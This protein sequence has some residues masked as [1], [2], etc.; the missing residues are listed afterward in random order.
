[1]SALYSSIIILILSFFQIKCL[2]YYKAEIIKSNE[3]VKRDIPTTE[4][5]F[6]IAYDY[7]NKYLKFKIFEIINTKQ[8]VTYKK[9]V[10]IKKTVKKEI[11]D[12]NYGSPDKPIAC[13]NFSIV[14]FLDDSMT[15][16]FKCS[17]GYWDQV[18][19]WPILSLG[20]PYLWTIP[21]VIF[22]S[23]TLPFRTL[24]DARTD[25]EEKSEMTDSKKKIPSEKM[26]LF[27]EDN[28]GER[29]KFQ[30]QNGIVSIP[31]A[32]IKNYES[33][34]RSG[35]EKFTLHYSLAGE[36]ESVTSPEL[37][38]SSTLEINSED[39]L[40]DK[41]QFE[42]EN[43]QREYNRCNKKFPTSLLKTG[44]SFIYK[45]IYKKEDEFKARILVENACKKYL[46][47]DS[48]DKC[49]AHF[50]D[51]IEISRKVDN[52]NSNYEAGEE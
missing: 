38:N 20:I 34:F 2:S 10:L 5:R 1:M 7:E 19:L 33:F 26:F 14:Y 49:V 37:V 30:I 48:Y 16:E 13:Q 42:K 35:K 39:F 36:K 11:G 15:S 40:K 4:K 3:I 52:V 46:G 25:F 8:K 45:G 23:I 43:D 21:A 24:D 51:C 50:R 41:I 18:F 17:L 27:L 28:Y 29:D 9:E 44:R 32:K 47:L 12:Y 22:D 6:I 31:I